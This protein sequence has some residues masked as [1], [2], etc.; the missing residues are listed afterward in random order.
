MEGKEQ[1]KTKNRGDEEG[2]EEEGVKEEE[3]M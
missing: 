2:T 1:K 3:M